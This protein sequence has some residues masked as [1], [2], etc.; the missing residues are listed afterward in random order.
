M[1]QNAEAFNGDLSKWDVSSATDMNRMFNRAAA[2]NG[3]LSKWDVSS[4]KNM[5]GMFWGAPF[6]GDISKWDV[7]SVTDMSFMFS[8][9]ESF[10]GDISKWDVSSVTAM[11]RMFSHAKSF[12]QKLCGAAWVNSEASKSDMFTGSSGSILTTGCTTTPAFSPQSK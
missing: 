3:D 1:F 5:H 11:L 10:N 2:F 4:V 7:S 8:T 12:K 9:A 6:G